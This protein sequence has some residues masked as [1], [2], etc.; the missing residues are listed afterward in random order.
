MQYWVSVNILTDIANSLIFSTWEVIN[1]KDE[2]Y[3]SLKPCPALLQQNIASDLFGTPYMQLRWNLHVS[4][5]VTHS[6]VLLHTCFLNLKWK[7][8]NINYSPF[9]LIFGM[10]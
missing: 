1:N 5:F 3:K 6:S 2:A 4:I 9:S 7:L 8:C 10:Q